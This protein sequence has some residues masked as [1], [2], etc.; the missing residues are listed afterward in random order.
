MKIIVKI[1]TQSVLNEDGTELHTAMQNIAYELADLKKQ[2]HEPVLVS[3]G[4]VG[5]GRRVLRSLG[6]PILSPSTPRTQMASS[7]GQAR[8]MDAW[9]TL[10]QPYSMIGA[11]I[12]LTRAELDT[13]APTE[14][15]RDNLE[16]CH[17]HGA[18]LPIVNEND[19]IATEELGFSDNDQL[20]CDLARLIR[21]DALVL[22]TG[23]DGI[24]DKDP[25][26]NP[27]ARRFAVLDARKE[28]PRIAGGIEA[29]STE[30][31]GGIE[32]KINS[33]FAAARAGIPT[34]IA[35]A[36]RMRVIAASL[37]YIS[38]QKPT[39]ATLVRMPA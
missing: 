12:L 15:L 21:A 8:L 33:A 22:L 20:A 10:L 6:A 23:S 36:H 37:A 30:G 39:N 28:P 34:V 32:S 5:L 31:R 38:G 18:V 9:N 24:Y 7:I 2:G 13:P 3:S 29:A 26:Y 35:H 14:R 16:A 25:R 27:N 17:A 4:A 19:A 11:Q 1:G